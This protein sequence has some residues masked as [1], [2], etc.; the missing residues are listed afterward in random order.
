MGKVFTGAK[1]GLP[2]G[3]ET[4]LLVEDDEQLLLLVRKILE[5]LEYKVLTAAAADEA[6]RLA[7]E[8]AGNIHLL[9]TDV[10]MPL[11]NGKE[12]HKLIEKLNPG[13]NALF[14][15]GY[16]GDIISRKG[17]LRKGVAFIQKPFTMKDLAEK[18]RMV[19]EAPLGIKLPD[20][21]EIG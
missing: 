17:E 12:L 1:T 20:G 6:L 18:V 16:T 11:M 9:L 15:S 7:A 21:Q 13:I 19:L 8:H 4:V 3:S 10:I 14:M 2:T 5:R